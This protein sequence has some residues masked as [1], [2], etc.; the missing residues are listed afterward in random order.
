M[1][2]RLLL[3]LGALLLSAAPAYAQLADELTL[4]QPA[5]CC[6]PTAAKNLAE[7]LLDWNQLGRYHAANEELKK[8]PPD[9][10][11]VVFIGDSI[12]DGWRLNEYFPGK[13]YVNRGISGQTTPQM[14]VR[15]YPDVIAL[16][17]AAV[18]IF[19]GTNDVARNTGPTTLEILQQHFMAMTDLAQKNN[20]K[21]FLCSITPVSDYTMLPAGRGAAAGAAPGRRI[22]TTGR[23]PADI[24]KINA[25]LKEYAAKVGAVYVDY[26]SAVVDAQGMLKDGIS[27]DGLHPNAEGY[28]LMA[29]VIAAALD[30]A[31]K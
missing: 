30:A 28:K 29:P 4:P 13:P 21:V 11:R 18:V 24:L 9:P 23:P 27:G 7:Q 19:A 15:M 6:L 16:K 25:W 17:P 14:V 26:F 5:N 31:I 3:C 10:K 8:Q 20:I 2:R 12:T 22:Q 1:P